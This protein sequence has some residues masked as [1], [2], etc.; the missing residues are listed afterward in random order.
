MYKRLID[1]K[2]TY[3]INKLIKDYSKNQYYKENACRYPSID[4][5]KDIN[6]KYK[7]IYIHNSVNKNNRKNKT[8]TSKTLNN[9][10]FPKI[11]SKELFKLGKYNNTCANFTKLKSEKINKRKKKFE[12]FNYNDLKLLK[13][14]IKIKTEIN[15]YD[16]KIKSKRIMDEDKEDLNN[17]DEDDDEDENE[18]KNEEEED[19]EE[20]EKEEEE[21]EEE[22]KEDEE[23]EDE[24]KEA[25]EYKK[26]ENKKDLNDTPSEIV[27]KDK[28]INNKRKKKI[29]KKIK[30]RNKNKVNIQDLS[31]ND[32]TSLLKKD[33]NDNENNEH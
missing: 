4:F 24:E 22:E 29:K 30:K 23:K 12:D 17:E 26:I 10:Y 2:P 9:Y 16:E 14:K 28:K 6:T 33:K 18:E 19:E 8:I 25:D 11:K 5:Y 32:E 31:E 7:N 1:K 21:K 13:N 27:S 20:E 3:D 15:N